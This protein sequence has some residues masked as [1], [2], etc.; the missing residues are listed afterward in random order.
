MV[1]QNVKNNQLDFKLFLYHQLA[2]QLADTQTILDD[3]DLLK[4]ELYPVARRG[5]LL[6][7]LM[8]SLAAIYPE[9][10]FTMEYFLHLF[11]EA[12]G[13]SL[14][15]EYMGTGQEDEVNIDLDS[16]ESSVEYEYIFQYDV[17]CCSS[18]VY[19]HLEGFNIIL[20]SQSSW[21]R[22]RRKE[23]CYL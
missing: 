16:E 7:S 5:S 21:K 10:R 17:V 2:H 19:I 14:P 20:C 4:D 22:T 9:L 11:D 13:G 15:E 3:L 8:R 1:D 12:V 6:Y 18:R 23:I